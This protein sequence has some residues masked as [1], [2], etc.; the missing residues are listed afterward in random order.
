MGNKHGGAGGLKRGEIR[1]FVAMTHFT[2]EEIEELHV[3]FCS[4]ACA[5]VDDGLIDASEF[6]QALGLSDSVFMDRM[7][8]LFDE[9]GDGNINFT[10]FICGLSI[11]CTRGTI[12]EKTQFSFRIYNSGGK[13]G[14]YPADLK[15]MLGATLKES[16]ITLT[17]A[18]L[19]HIV[20]NTF[21]QVGKD[22][23]KEAIDLAAY[24]DLVTKSPGILSNMTL[25]FKKLIA[26]SQDRSG[27]L[28]EASA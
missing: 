15:T 16:K 18:Q 10:E 28:K 25:D 22:P 3:H 20:T 11:L 14:I 2:K 24:A 1:Q 13:G 4:I 6:Q 21:E 27:G 23:A 8:A 17:D 26:E 7:F 12:E 19:D 5:D 9:N